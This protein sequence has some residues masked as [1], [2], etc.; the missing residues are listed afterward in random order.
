MP[1]DKRTWITDPIIDKEDRFSKIH[2]TIKRMLPYHVQLR[3]YLTAVQTAQY[4]IPTLNL[5]L[6][7]FC[8]YFDYE[9][10]V[11]KKLDLADMSKTEF[12]VNKL[13]SKIQILREETDRLIKACTGKIVAN[14]TYPTNDIAY[15]KRNQP[16]PIVRAFVEDKSKWEE[17]FT[18]CQVEKNF[19]SLP[20][21]VHAVNYVAQSDGKTTAG[22]DNVAFKTMLRISIPKDAKDKQ[23]LKIEKIKECHPCFNILRTALG[24]QNLAV[25]R[26]KA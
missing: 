10:Q 19:N 11:M 26:K 12:D 15:T 16:E 4:F 5:E 22:I 6:I 25:Q 3:Q 20:F 24:K 2:D 17:I 8:N 18:K 13:S 23:K 9:I 14:T 1:K 21:K 7:D